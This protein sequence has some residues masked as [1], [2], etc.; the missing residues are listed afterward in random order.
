MVKKW[1][2]WLEICFQELTIHFYLGL[3]VPIEMPSYKITWGTSCW[4]RLQ[5]LLASMHYRRQALMKQRSLQESREWA[6]L[7]EKQTF[8]S[9]SVYPEP[10][11]EFTIV[12]AGRGKKKIQRAWIHFHK[13]LKWM[14]LELRVNKLITKLRE[15]SQA[16]L[17]IQRYNLENLMI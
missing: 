3:G 8:S 11:T 5:E 14:I 1:Q 7:T 4:G 9:Y 17:Y 16:C 12:L 6:Q 10:S 15:Q 2:N 13:H